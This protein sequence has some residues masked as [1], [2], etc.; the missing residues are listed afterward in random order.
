M[1]ELEA[2]SGAVGRRV[3]CGT[4]GKQITSVSI[5]RQNKQV[6]WIADLSELLIELV[7]RSIEAQRCWSMNQG[8]KDSTGSYL[9]TDWI[10]GW[11]I[12]WPDHLNVL[13]LHRF[14]WVTQIN[15]C[16]SSPPTYPLSPRM[17]ICS[18][19]SAALLLHPHT[20]TLDCVRT[21]ASSDELH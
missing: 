17:A 6:I 5:W 19:L 13:R 21:H 1:N 7:V 12:N 11:M 3:S 18:C 8:P 2:T 10:N 20:Q 15:Q 14:Q 4:A 9:M 16:C